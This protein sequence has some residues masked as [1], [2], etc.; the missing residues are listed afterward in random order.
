MVKKIIIA[1]AILLVLLIAGFAAYFAYIIKKPVSSDGE[2]IV[3]EI[4]KNT[5]TLSVAKN[6]KDKELINSTWAFAFYTKIAKK[7]ILPGAYVLSPDMTTIEIATKISSNDTA[8]WKITTPEG[9]R[10]EQIGQYLEENKY[11]DYRRFMAA[12][13]GLEGKLFPD[14]YYIKVGTSEESIVKVMT[15]NYAERTAEMTVSEADLILASIVER[16]AKHDPD[17]PV[18]AGIFKNRLAIGM[19][20][21]SNPTVQYGYD[22]MQIAKSGTDAITYE[23]WDSTDGKAFSSINSPFNTYIYAGLP[24]TPICNPGLKSIKAAMNYTK[25]NYFYFITDSSGNLHPARTGAEH[26]ANVNKYLR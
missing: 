24:P 12:A 20:L 9:W 19:K 10:A 22:S 6:L 8:I 2:K 23:F 26:Q 17:R 3:F 11:G 18:I 21:E 16:E 14:T 5:P 13:S 25:S 15:E 1:A 7:K 4:E